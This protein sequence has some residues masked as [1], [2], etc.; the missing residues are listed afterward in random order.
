[1]R[2][3]DTILEVTQI[4]DVLP[5]GATEP[6]SCI[7]EN[8]MTAVVKYMRNPFG[9][10]VL[11]NE[12][13]GACIAD[14][15]GLIIPEYGIC[16]IS[17]EVIESANDTEEIDERNAGFGFFSASYSKTVPLNSNLLPDIQ[18]KQTELL[19]LFDHIVNNFDRHNGNILVSMKSPAHLFFIDNSHIITQDRSLNIEKEMERASIVSTMLLDKNKDIYDLLCYRVGYNEETLT[20]EATRIQSIL[21]EA[22]LHDI[23][24]QIPDCWIQSAEQ[25]YVDNMFLVI[26]H[27]IAAISDICDMIIR[28]RRR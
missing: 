13:V 20:S 11:I 3:I 26:Q 12:L 7:L 8:G 14:E 23:K 10:Q 6:I 27:R 1:M 2:R 28:E 25:A 18:N 17:Q 9:Q 21:S 22:K 16:N 5:E 24:R 15:L 19:I 4:I